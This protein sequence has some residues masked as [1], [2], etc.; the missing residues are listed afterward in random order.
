LA[1]L[2]QLGFLGIRVRVRLDKKL[3]NNRE[4]RVSNGENE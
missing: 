3:E 1:V 2:G 4:Y